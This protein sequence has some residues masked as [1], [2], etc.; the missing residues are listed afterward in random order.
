MR[1]LLNISQLEDVLQNKYRLSNC[2]ID[3][4]HSI[5]NYFDIKIDNIN[6]FYEWWC[7][8]PDD[9]KELSLRTLCERFDTISRYYDLPF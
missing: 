7:N 2:F 6:R 9:I 5:N 4:I 8:K 1:E 3:G